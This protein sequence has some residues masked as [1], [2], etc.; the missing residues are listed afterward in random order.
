[1]HCYGLVETLCR[2]LTG[3]GVMIEWP[4]Q[5][6]VVPVFWNRKPDEKAAV[7][8]AAQAVVELLQAADIQAGIDTTNAMSP[9]QKYRFW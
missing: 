3:L 6:I 1:M 5:V 8:K 9:G 4:V 7:I 2:R